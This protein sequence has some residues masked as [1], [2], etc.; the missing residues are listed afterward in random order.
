MEEA[1]LVQMILQPEAIIP[2]LIFGAIWVLFEIIWKLIEPYVMNGI[3]S[4]S[5]LLPPTEVIKQAV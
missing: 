3:K 2:L 4:I 1:T 5:G